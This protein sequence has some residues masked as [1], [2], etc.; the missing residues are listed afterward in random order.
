[1][2]LGSGTIT[3]EADPIR[4]F[5]SFARPSFIPVDHVRSDGKR[6]DLH[7]RSREAHCGDVRGNGEADKHHRAMASA[8]RDLGPREQGGCG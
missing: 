7:P 1:M 3:A 6:K 5:F 8:S 2:T 4:A